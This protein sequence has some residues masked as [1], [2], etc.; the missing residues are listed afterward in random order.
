[1]NAAST[2]AFVAGLVMLTGLD[3]VAAQPLPQPKRGVCP[4]GYASGAHYCT[5][6]PST[7]RDAV[8]ASAPVLA[9]GFRAG[10]IAC[11]RSEGR[12]AVRVRLT[13]ARIKALPPAR[14]GKRYDCRDEVVTGLLV[15][16]TDTG[17]KSYMFAARF[18]GARHKGPARRRINAVGAITVEQARATARTWAEQ[19]TRGVDPKAEERKREAA[20]R[21]A[22]EGRFPLVA[23]EYL[24]RRANRRRNADVARAVRNVLVPA[25]RDKLVTEI[26]RR[27]VIRL[28]EQ[29]EARGRRRTGRYAGQ[30]SSVYAQQVYGY[31]RALFR[32]CIQRDLLE[33]SPCDG[34]RVEELVE[35]PKDHR[36]R[37]LSDEELRAFWSSAEQLGHPW[38][39]WYQFLLLTGARRSEAAFMRW[40]EFRDGLWSVPLERHKSK[41]PHTVPLSRAAQDLL[42][43]LPGGR[44]PGDLVFQRSRGRPLID[45]SDAKDRLDALMAAALGEAPPHWRVHDLRHTV[46]TR[47]AALRVN[48]GVAEKCLGHAARGLQRIYDQYSYSEEMLGAFEAWAQALA[49]VLAGQPFRPERRDNVVPLVRAEA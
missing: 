3:P 46:R 17:A 36:T 10:H 43:S 42:A 25:W 6:M 35:R 20:A 45:F 2:S 29:V 15:R 21:L 44:R 30:P 39:S 11:R 9:T 5:P 32:W 12:T 8:P 26:T 16:V 38:G 37:V 7:Q 1:M 23:E 48:D 14:K 49:R 34:L 40:S 13:E 27:D 41:I 33:R 28:V 4:A 19:I 47:M 24:A 18:P 31:A 22:Q